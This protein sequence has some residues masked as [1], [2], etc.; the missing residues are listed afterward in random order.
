[1]PR[2]TWRDRL[3]DMI[4][5]IDDI[6]AHLGGMDLDAFTL[7]RRTVHAV[8]RNFIILGEA[9]NALPEAVLKRAP[10][11]PWH[12]VRGMRNILAHEYFRADLAITWETAV[13]D[14]PSLRS[15]LATLREG[16]EP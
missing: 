10:E 13:G 11:V 4:Q 8:E 1:M 12:R 2:R 3:D 6:T 9:A 5:A 15:V 7:D 14:L 16:D